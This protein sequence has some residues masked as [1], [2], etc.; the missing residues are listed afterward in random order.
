M[1]VPSS[2][3]IEQLLVAKKK[4]MLLAKYAT[5]EEVKRGAESKA[6]AMSTK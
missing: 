5:P 4:E 2:E 1:S 6:L 3:E